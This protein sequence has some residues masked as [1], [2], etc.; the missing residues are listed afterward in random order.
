MPAWSITIQSKRAVPAGRKGGFGLNR[1]SKPPDYLLPKKED[2]EEQQ[3][4]PAGEWQNPDLAPG[5]GDYVDS[6]TEL[7]GLYDKG[8]IETQEYETTQIRI[9]TDLDPQKNGVEGGLVLL[10]QLWDQGLISEAPY[11]TK[12]QEMLDAL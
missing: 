5:G 2:A 7:K 11:A 1:R 10:R 6:L 12:R 9:L 8:L 3:S 4:D